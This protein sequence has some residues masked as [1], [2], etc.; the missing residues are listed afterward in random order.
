MPGPDN[1]AGRENAQ[2]TLHAA[3]GRETHDLP[4]DAD[5]RAGRAVR[6]LLEEQGYRVEWFTSLEAFRGVC[7]Q[8]ELP[9][10]P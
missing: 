5:Q 1:N 3:S 6:Q 2:S 10:A 4:G 8:G 9:S 7:S